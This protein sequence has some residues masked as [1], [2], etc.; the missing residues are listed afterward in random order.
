M[1][2]QVMFCHI[3]VSLCTINFKVLSIIIIYLHFVYISL[4]SDVIY[5]NYEKSVHKMMNK[6]KQ[7]IS[8]I[9]IVIHSNK[10]GNMSYRHI[11]FLYG[12]LKFHLSV[13]L[14]DFQSIR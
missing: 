7:N 9:S 12:Q 8:S 13:I 5:R 10:T 2:I 11:F 1:C 3:F 4:F 6:M 14:T